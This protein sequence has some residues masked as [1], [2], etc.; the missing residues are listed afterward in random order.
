MLQ[1]KIGEF[2]LLLPTWESSFFDRELD[3]TQIY[4]FYMHCDVT[5]GCHW[6]YSKANGLPCSTRAWTS[7]KS[8]LDGLLSQAGPIQLWL[9]ILVPPS[10]K[11]GMI[12]WSDPQERCGNSFVHPSLLS[13]RTVIMNYK[14]LTTETNS[15]ALNIFRCFL[16]QP[17]Q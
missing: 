16:T 9:R 11:H 2:F 6:G 10:L 3:W 12:R 1:I 13:W 4:I 8:S 7:N 14:F 15:K 17:H 5:G